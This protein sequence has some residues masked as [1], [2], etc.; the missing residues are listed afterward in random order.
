VLPWPWKPQY[1]Q[2]E[3]PEAVGSNA[4]AF[5][6]KAG[7]DLAKDVAPRVR[8]K[9][10]VIEAAISKMASDGVIVAH[11]GTAVGYSLYLKEGRLC[12]ATR[13]SGEQTVV[14]SAQALAASTMRVGATLKRDGTV[15]LTADGKEVG[16]GKVPGPMER[17]PQDGLQVGQDKN[18]AVGDYAAPFRFAG[19]IGE[20]TVRLTEE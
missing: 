14:E 11:G 7:D 19:E 1:G 5:K 6:L 9:G 15:T 4:T 3:E 12:F 2:K 17:M 20:V 16:S 13:H 18:A 8:G 10:I